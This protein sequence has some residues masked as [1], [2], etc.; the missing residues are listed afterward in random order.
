MKDVIAIVLAAGLGTRMNSRVPKVLH[1]ILGKPIIAHI[2]DSLRDAGVKEVITVAGYGSDQLREVV[3]DAE[4]VVQK[5]LLGSGDAVK[6]AMKKIGRYSGDI[7]V[8]CGDTPLIRS[9]DIRGL[10]ERHKMSKAGLTLMTA[11]L[12]DPTSYG[13]IVRD[14][15][16]RIVKIVEE[17]EARLFEEV[18]DEINVGTYCFK[19]NDLSEAISLITP[20]SNKKE[21][22]LTD[23]IEIL[24][25]NGKTIESLTIKDSE[26]IIGVNNR[27]EL[28]EATRILKDRIL[29]DIMLGGVTVEDPLSTTIYTG[30]KIGRDSIIHPNTVIES[31][32]EIGGDCH[33]GPFARIR[34]GVR[35]GDGVE[36]GNFVELTRT[37]IGDQTKVKHHT[38][39][40]DTTVGRNVNVGAGTITANYDG[41]N[42]N[43]TIIEDRAFIGV[44]AVLIAPV[45]V[46]K[47]AVVGAGCVVPRN[48]NVPDGATVIGV[49][50]RIMKSR[51]RSFGR[52]KILSRAKSRDKIDR[53]GKRVLK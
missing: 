3:K 48:H 20:N 44:G 19:A 10:L 18:I 21:Y 12:K 16:G 40:G 5:K 2:F 35:I 4:V 42:K 25:K 45:K 22:F 27:K 9:D 37:R 47:G 51:G 36:I 11:R 6:T 49:P 7:L 50:A 24:R 38:Y 31:D 17:I 29:N 23:T 13:R 52:L 33:I 26:S 34:S 53:R 32:V 14:D 46:G 41:K 39:L 43:K 1:E 30:V 15:T 8:V 28:A